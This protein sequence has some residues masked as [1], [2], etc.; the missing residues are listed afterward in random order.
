[1]KKIFMRGTGIFATVPILITVFEYSK[2]IYVS[3]IFSAPIPA[4]AIRGTEEEKTNEPE[5]RRLKKRKKAPPLRS[6]KPQA[7]PFRAGNTENGLTLRRFVRA[8]LTPFAPSPFGD[9]NTTT[10]S[11]PPAF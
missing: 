1:M 11:P 4:V 6:G 10:A 2:L 7:I 3:S 8:Y 5:G 9:F